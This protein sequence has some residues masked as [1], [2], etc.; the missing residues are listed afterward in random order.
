[1]VRNPLDLQSCEFL[2]SGT[3]QLSTMLSQD[4]IGAMSGVQ[5]DAIIV[6]AKCKVMR[7]VFLKELHTGIEIIR[8]AQCS[9]LNG[10]SLAKTRCIHEVTEMDSIVRF[11]VCYEI[12]EL[13]LRV[14]T[15]QIPMRITA[16]YEFLP[17]HKLYCYSTLLE[18]IDQT[19]DSSAS[20]DDRCGLCWLEYN[21]KSSYHLDDTAPCGFSFQI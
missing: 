8:D 10:A 14:L 4:A 16:Y 20:S 11:P 21:S 13:L 12:K 17:T 1:M 15:N 3:S 7:F 19:Y 5:P 2:L 18:G 9:L 6:V